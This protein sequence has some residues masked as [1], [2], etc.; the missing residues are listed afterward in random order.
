MDDEKEEVIHLESTNVVSLECDNHIN[1]EKCQ[2]A[3]MIENGSRG[4]SENS[5]QEEK[6]SRKSEQIGHSDP[7]KP[8][9][10]SINIPQE[11]KSPRIK[12][13]RYKKRYFCCGS[14]ADGAIASAN[15]S[16]V[17]YRSDRLRFR[18]FFADE[19]I[20]LKFFEENFDV[21]IIKA[22]SF[23]A[24]VY[25]ICYIRSGTN[26]KRAIAEEQREKIIPWILFTI[27]TIFCL[28]SAA[29]YVSVTYW[30]EL[31]DFD[32]DLTT[33]C[34]RLIL[35]PFLAFVGCT[36]IYCAY[37]VI[38]LF[39]SMALVQTPGSSLMTD[40]RTFINGVSV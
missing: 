15:Y 4:K 38:R 36:L 10:V 26:L 25:A 20:I 23:S 8:R 9:S 28:L 19:E 1:P 24:V 14:L 35:I 6:I 34:L 39:Q 18:C 30:E 33:P 22:F 21:R 7:E 12:R 3:S 37:G 31:D 40:I 32:E 27:S 13:P 17:C 2:N 11:K 16:N 29:I 5:V